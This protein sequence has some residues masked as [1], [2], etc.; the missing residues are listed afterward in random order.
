M[1]SK[2]CFNIFFSSTENVCSK[3]YFAFQCMQSVHTLVFAPLACIAFVAFGQS[4]YGLAIIV[5]FAII[6]LFLFI[7]LCMG[8]LIAK[9]R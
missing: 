2:D 4:G 8:R 1:N 6:L 3:V 9:F 5:G 7:R